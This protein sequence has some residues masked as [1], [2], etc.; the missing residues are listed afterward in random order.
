MSEWDDDATGYRESPM[1]YDGGLKTGDEASH[2][3]LDHRVF[4]TCDSVLSRRT[5]LSLYVKY[6]QPPRSVACPVCGRKARVELE[7]AGPGY[8]PGRVAR[9]LRRLGRSANPFGDR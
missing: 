8:G 4:I 7:Q 1:A 9:G 2:F 3:D 5:R 6:G